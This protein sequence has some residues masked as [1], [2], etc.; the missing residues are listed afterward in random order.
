MLIPDRTH[1]VVSYFFKNPLATKIDRS[2]NLATKINSHICLY[3]PLVRVLGGEVITISAS[4]DQC[5]YINALDLELFTTGTLNVFSHQINI[6]L[7]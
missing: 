4:N 6:Q 2:V 3:G 1:T 5:S 7:R